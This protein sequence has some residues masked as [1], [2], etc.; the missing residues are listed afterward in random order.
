M[1]NLSDLK[2]ELENSLLFMRD[3]TVTEGD[4][5]L[6]IVDVDLP[7]LPVWLTVFGDKMECWVNLCPVKSV[8][9]VDRYKLSHFLLE[10]NELTN[11]SSF[12]I[13]QGNYK[14][15]G[16]LSANSDIDLIVQDL[17]SLFET[18]R[19]ALSLFA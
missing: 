18:S 12:S 5:F 7:E 8:A 4:N 11:L 10:S 3:V 6:K 19:E 16:K 15:T 9:E 1:K 2:L 14:L 13:G 17:E